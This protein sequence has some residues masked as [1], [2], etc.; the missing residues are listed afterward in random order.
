VTDR[1]AIERDLGWDLCR[2]HALGPVFERMARRGR[3]LVRATH[4]AMRLEGAAFRSLTARKI[5]ADRC[6]VFVGAYSYGECLLPGAFPPG[7]VVGRYVS[8]ACGVR[9]F[10]RNHPYDRLSMHPFFYNAALGFVGEDTIETG[11]LRIE[12]DAWIGERAIV[13]PGCRRIGLG[14]VVG[15][16]AVVTRDVP[17]FAIV[18]GNPAKVLKMRFD[19]ATQQRVRDSRWWERPVEE[20]AKDID[21]MQAPVVQSNHP[22]LGPTR[23]PVAQA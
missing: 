1:A 22:L 20:V 2:R 7:V 13:T 11:S 6:G 17:D 19:E 12:H 8:M 4:W 18:A 3:L 10:L 16:G 23:E 9:V 21:G 14:A 15:A 5:L